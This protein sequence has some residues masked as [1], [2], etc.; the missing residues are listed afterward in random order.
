MQA[1]LVREGIRQN[2]LQPPHPER[3]LTQQLEGCIWGRR[4]LV[5][6]SYFRH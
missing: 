6:I 1:R 3:I 5:R 2:R 4:Q